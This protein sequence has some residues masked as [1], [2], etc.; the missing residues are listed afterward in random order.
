MRPATKPV[1]E[2]QASGELADVATLVCG[3]ERDPD[4]L[5]TGPAGSPDAVH[6]RLAVVRRIEVDHVRDSGHI[7]AARGDI[8]GDEHVDR[9]RLEA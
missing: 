9:T 8:G 3:D 7:D 4:P 1:R 2:P 5:G 6:V